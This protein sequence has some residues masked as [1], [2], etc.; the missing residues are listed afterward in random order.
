M[1]ACHAAI[2]STLEYHNY[3]EHPHLCLCSVDSLSQL[4]TAINKLKAAD[5]PFK[6]WREPDRNN[7]ITAIATAPLQGDARIALKSFQLFKIK[8]K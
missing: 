5:I 8:E 3:Q 1:Q 6:I 7:E 2:E 4:E